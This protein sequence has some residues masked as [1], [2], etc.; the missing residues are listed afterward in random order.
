MDAWF[1]EQ[2]RKIQITAHSF[3]F[4]TQMNNYMLICGS[5]FLQTNITYNKYILKEQMNE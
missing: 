2:M 1:L 5:L 3:V 4:L